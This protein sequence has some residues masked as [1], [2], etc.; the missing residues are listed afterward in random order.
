MTPYGYRN[1]RV[2]GRSIVEIDVQAAE[3]VKRIFNLYAYER[4]TL[5]M[6]CRRLVSDGINYLPEKP[7]WTRS[8]VHNIL[9]DRSYIGDLRYQER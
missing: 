2:D 9:R 4:N 5:D 1:V 6:I 7:A 3:N 8:K